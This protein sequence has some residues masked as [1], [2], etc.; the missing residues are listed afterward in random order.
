MDYLSKMKRR[1]IEKIKEK[2]RQ[3]NKYIKHNHINTD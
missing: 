1:K 3:Q 2:E